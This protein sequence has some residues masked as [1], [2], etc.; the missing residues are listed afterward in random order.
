MSIKYKSKFIGFI[1]AVIL[2]GFIGQALAKYEV[3][4]VQNGGTIKGVATWSGKVP[5]IDPLQVLADMDVCG[6]TV[7]SPV[8]QVD[9]KTKGL[10][11]TLVYLEK[12]EKGKAP[13]DKYMLY[14]GKTEDRPNSQLCNFEEHIFPF[15]HTQRVG[16]INFDEILHNPHFYND[17]HRTLLNIAMP[18]P[19]QE[20]DHTIL[21]EHGVGWPYQCDVHAHMNGYS[22]GFLHPYFAVTDATGKYEIKDIPPGKYTV[23]A[24]HESYEITKLK[25][26]RPQYGDPQTLQQDI[27]VKP[28]GTVEANWSFP[29]Q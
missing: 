20:V 23:V 11:F 12:V 5:E 19:N 25:Q 16:M 13:K 4:T 18:T 22:A 2:L 9:P 21:R 3:V 17:K 7:P 8:L 15:V 29:A 10:K 27:E 14:M 26:G 24:W 6:A 1:S 28:G